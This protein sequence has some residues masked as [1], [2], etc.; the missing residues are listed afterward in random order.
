MTSNEAIWVLLNLHEFGAI[1]KETAEE[2]LD[3]AI[4]AIKDRD[5]TR[6]VMDDDRK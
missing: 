5:R 6:E 3:Y 4:G 1:P 2:A